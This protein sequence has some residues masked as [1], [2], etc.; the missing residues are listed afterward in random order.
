MASLQDI[1][2]HGKEFNKKLDCADNMCNI[3]KIKASAAVQKLEGMGLEDLVRE[4]LG[5]PLMRTL[6]ELAAKGEEAGAWVDILNNVNMVRH[7]VAIADGDQ[8][9]EDPNSML[10]S[11]STTIKGSN[12]TY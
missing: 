11:G 9:L 1:A 5:S 8:P 7:F 4:P 10:A 12:R 6:S 2:A 3:L